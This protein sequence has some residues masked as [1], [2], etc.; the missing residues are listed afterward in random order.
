MAQNINIQFVFHPRFA[1]PKMK[2]IMTTSQKATRANAVTTIISSIGMLIF[3]KQLAAMFEMT[4]SWPFLVLGGVIT[5][6]ALTIFIEIRRQRALALLWIIPQDLLFT[7][8]CLLVIVIRPFGISDIGYLMIALYI[9][10]IAFFIIYQGIGLSQLDTKKGSN[11]K[12]LTFH[13]VVNADIDIVWSAISD[14]GNY[15]KVAPNIDSTKIISGHKEGMIRSCS[16]GK[17]SWTETCTLW[18]DKKQ[19]S[20]AVNTQA[21]DYPYPLKSLNGNWSVLSTTHG[22][23]EISMVFEFE[24]KKQIQNILIHPIMKRQFTKVCR[25][26]LDNWQKMVE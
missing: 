6:F 5:F 8:T 1:L 4:Y 7:I 25:E 10:P 19:Y 17:N 12:Q 15:H 21:P 14:V 16:H 24:Y 20:F 11:I 22:Q 3:H 18:E 23:T 26:L 2:T 13:R 9:L